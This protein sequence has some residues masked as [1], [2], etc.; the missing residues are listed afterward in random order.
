MTGKKIFLK[1]MGSFVFAWAVLR[2]L[3]GGQ[4]NIL[5]QISFFLMYGPLF[6]ADLFLILSVFKHDTGILFA[7]SVLSWL[8]L[9]SFYGAFAY[10][11]SLVISR[12]KK[13]AETTSV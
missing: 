8:F 11:I 13:P 3:S 7:P 4:D 1:V 6:F 2:V 9:I 12:L 10:V 5:G